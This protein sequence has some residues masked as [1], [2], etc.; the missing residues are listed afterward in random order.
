MGEKDTRMEIACGT[1]TCRVVQGDKVEVTELPWEQEE[2]SEGERE[3]AILKC[4]T[5]S[6]I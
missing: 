2:E 4:F 3:R 5:I 6:S 1:P